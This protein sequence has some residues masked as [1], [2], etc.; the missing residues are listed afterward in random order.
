MALDDTLQI[1]CTRCKA[2]FRDKARKVQTGYSRQCPGCEGV[3]Y[4][5]EGS[6]DANVQKA[7]AS[8]FCTR[9]N[10]QLN[11]FVSLCILCS[12]RYFSAK[13]SGLASFPEK[14][15]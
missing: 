7:L 2:K 6:S 9:L 11:C 13:R 10:S 4:F 12:L 8:E 5:E 14:I 1:S 15:T 3:I